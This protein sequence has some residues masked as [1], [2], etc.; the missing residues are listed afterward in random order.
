VSK[1]DKLRA[2]LAKKPPPK[3]FSWDELITLMKANDFSVSCGSG[4]HHRF[5]HTSGLTLSISK[6]HPSGLLKA[7][8]VKSALEALDAI[9]SKNSNTSAGEQP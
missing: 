7:Y 5:Q 9:D 3:D 8:Q 1:Q 2:R 4:S 6:T